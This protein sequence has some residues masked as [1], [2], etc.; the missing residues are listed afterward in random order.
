[1]QFVKS[2][3]DIP[4]TLLHRHEDG[5]VVFFCGAG[6]SYPAQLPGFHDL[7]QGIYAELH[8]SP[9]S[10]EEEAT[11]KKQYDAT[12]NLL[13]HRIPGGRFAVRSALARVLKPKLKKSGA[14]A[15]HK[16]LL[17]LARSRDGNSRLI[18][19]NFD[20]IFES[21]MS[22]RTRRIPTFSAPLLPIP[23]DSKWHGLVYL[24]GLLPKSPARQNRL[25]PCWRLDG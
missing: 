19:T 22:D 24:H 11:N 13:E 14:T 15:I 9:D 8:A 1:M 3:P 5:S 7:V 23:K 20:R 25:Q 16:A 17:A 10:I 4:D 18:T 21:V 12:I 6:I 2:G